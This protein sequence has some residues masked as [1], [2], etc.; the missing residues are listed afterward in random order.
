[1][2]VSTHKKKVKDK[3][4][5]SYSL[6]TSFRD[7]KGKVQHKHIANLPKCTDDEINALKLAL[8]FNLPSEN[9]GRLR[10]S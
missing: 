4:Y 7:A 8:S 3:L 5:I 9:L 10:P 2:Y 6:R 1:M